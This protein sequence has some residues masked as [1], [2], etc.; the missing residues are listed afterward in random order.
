MLSRIR[1]A[2]GLAC[3]LALII[4][5]A[6]L[7]K[8]GFSF[9]SISGPGIDEDIRA[10]D[11]KLTEDFFAFADF[12]RDKVETPKDPGMGY[13]ISRYY[14]D[15]KR[16]ILFDQLHYYPSTGF[17]FYDG[18]VNGDSEYD[19]EWYS[20]N[21]AIKTVFESTLG[22]AVS[23]HVQPVQQMEKQ[24]PAAGPV[25]EVLPSAPIF[26]SNIWMPVTILAGL[27]ALA[28][29]ALKLRKTVVQ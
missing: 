15:G 17:V 19:G 6:V 11:L 23:D 9:L 2:V 25:R 28:A 27:L 5:M 20:A 22:T 4:S 1:N 12:Y 8:G 3:L 26:P 21:P 10:S 7:A 18:I 13:E 29:L 24:Q 16:E 14:I